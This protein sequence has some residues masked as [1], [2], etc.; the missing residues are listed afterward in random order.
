MIGAAA[1]V[2]AL[3]AW[4]AGLTP[5]Y[6]ADAPVGLGTAGSYAV[7]GGQTVTNTGPTVLNRDLGV[8]PGT[9]I[10]G[11]PPGQTT[12]TL[13]SAD[14]HAAQAQSDLTI[15][16]N[17]AAG[18]PS[19]ASVG[20]LVSETLLPGVYTAGSAMAVN[21]ALTLDGQGN[22]NSV[23]IFQAGSTLTTASGSSIVLTNSA[24]ACNIFWQVGSSAT[25]GTGTSFKGNIMALTS[26]SVTTGVTIEGR[27]LARN[28]AVTL[29]TNV[30]LAPGC[31]TTPTG[32]ATATVTPT[33]TTT[34]TPTQTSTV[35]ATQTTTALA[36][37]TATATDTVSPSTT[38]PSTT[39]AA[40][41]PLE[42]STTTPA[43]DAPLADTGE[44]AARNSGV[45]IDSAAHAAQETPARL[46]GVAAALIALAAAIYLGW[47]LLIPARR[48]VG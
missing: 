10:T 42:T 25:L 22:A 2:V 20:V 3:F 4:L 27:A 11:F 8:S 13:H 18:R 40:V 30:F 7:L 41:A 15:A 44:G 14:A 33:E 36:T 31:A 9:A 46:A 23:F 5:A 32:T 17:D 28:G 34:V 21:G 24:Q 43:N 38:T 48:R 39:P 35:T 6:A 19:S 37:Q 29:D 1:T 47:T 12:G 45:N 16:Y 26:I